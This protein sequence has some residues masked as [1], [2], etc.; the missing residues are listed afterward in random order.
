[1]AEHLIKPIPPENIPAYR[2]PYQILTG[3]ELPIALNN[4]AAI[5]SAILDGIAA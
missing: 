3:R 5:R 4:H 2:T 1:M